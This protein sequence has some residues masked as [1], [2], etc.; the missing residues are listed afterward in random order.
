MLTT[1]RTDVLTSGR[2]MMYL[3]YE[4]VPWAHADKRGDKSRVSCRA[5]RL[6][7]A[8]GTRSSPRISIAYPPG[9]PGINTKCFK[10]TAL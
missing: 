9:A 7:K 3:F 6:C 4:L 8:A 1:L 2:S 5:R 10:C